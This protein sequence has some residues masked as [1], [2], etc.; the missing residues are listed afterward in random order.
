MINKVIL[1][2]RLGDDPSVRYTQSNETIAN[3]S[4]ATSENWKD[5]QTGERKEK[6]EW[7]RVVFFGKLAEIVSEYLK[8]GSKIYVEGKLQTRK[9]QDSNGVDKYTTEIV[10]S[11]MQMLDSKNENQQAQYHQPPQQQTPQYQPQAQPQ[12]YQPQ[13][14][15]VYQNQQ[16]AV[17]HVTPPPGHYYDPGTNQFYPAQ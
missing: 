13:Q 7:H 11:V 9:W 6:T 8:K 1:L 17:S 12:Q 10:A 2:G 14:H 4:L 3:I 16:H 15:Q 5:K